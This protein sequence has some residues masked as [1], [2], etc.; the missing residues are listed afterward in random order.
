M[1]T[2]SVYKNTSVHRTRQMQTEEVFVRGMKYTNTPHEPGYAKTIVNFNIKNDGEVFAPRGGLRVVRSEVTRQLL[3]TEVHTDYCVHHTHMMYV[4][5]ETGDAILCHYILASTMNDS[6]QFLLKNAKLIIELNNDYL[7]A[8]YDNLESTAALLMQPACTAM[9]EMPIVNPKK[10]S[11]I[12]TSLEGNTYILYQDGVTQ[13]YF[14]GR[15][16]ATLSS[17]NVLS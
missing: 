8:T 12:F 9:H 17:S 15:I 2:T 3:D 5:T 13:K 6:E 10:R 4:K 11:G 14:L 7:E 1:P 16:A